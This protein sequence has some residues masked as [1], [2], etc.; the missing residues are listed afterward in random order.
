VQNKAN[1]AFIGVLVEGNAYS[2]HASPQRWNKDC[3]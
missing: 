3:M 2:L 1:L